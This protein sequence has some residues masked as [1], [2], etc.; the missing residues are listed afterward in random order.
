MFFHPEHLAYLEPGLF[1]L[2]QTTTE[3]CE[4]IRKGIKMAGRE[5]DGPKSTKQGKIR[6]MI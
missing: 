2:Y 3:P 5:H 6:N 4:L 1:V